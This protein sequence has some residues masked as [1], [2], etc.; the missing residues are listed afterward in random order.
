MSQMWL[1]I[2]YLCLVLSLLSCDSTEAMTCQGS[3]KYKFPF[4]AE[5]TAQSHPEDFPSG[6]NPHFSSVVGCSHNSSYV[7]WKPGELA[8]QGVKLVAELGSFIYFLQHKAC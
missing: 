7:M 3:E 4:Q 2:V 5:W 1:H 8:S 6:Y